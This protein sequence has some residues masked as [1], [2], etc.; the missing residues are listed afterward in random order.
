MCVCVGGCGGGGLN[1]D[2]GYDKSPTFN[3]RGTFIW[4][5]RA[6]EI[7]PQGSLKLQKC[8]HVFHKSGWNRKIL[9]RSEFYSIRLIY[10]NAILF[11]VINVSDISAFWKWNIELTKFFSGIYEMYSHCTKLILQWLYMQK[12][13]TQDIT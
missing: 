7:L 13:S 3:K 6:Y 2:G 1:K 12:M 8:L 9:S 5:R 10:K 11:K 4:H